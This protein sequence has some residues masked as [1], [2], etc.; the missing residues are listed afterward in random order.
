M[1]FALAHLGLA[2]R[3]RALDYLEAAYRGRLRDMAWLNVR[4]YLAP[5]RGHPRFQALLARMKF[6]P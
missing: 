6:P 2:D 1:Q 3:E 4:P 5:L